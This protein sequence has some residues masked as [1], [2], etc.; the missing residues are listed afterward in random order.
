M[1]AVVPREVTASLNVAYI[2]Q[3]G[4][5]TVCKL[6]EVWDPEDPPEELEGWKLHVRRP[7][8]FVS[9][10]LNPSLTKRI[11]LL[12]VVVRVCV[13]LGCSLFPSK[14]SLI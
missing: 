7:E 11:D 6:T 14:T 1:G 10:V 3:L 8:S 2:P 4:F 9:A 12:C 13:S 5:L